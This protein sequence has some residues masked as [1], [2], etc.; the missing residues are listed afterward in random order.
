MLEPL[1]HWEKHDHFQETANA[2]FKHSLK[3]WLFAAYILHVKTRSVLAV[4]ESYCR[5]VQQQ[6][7]RFDHIRCATVY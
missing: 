7:E 2:V 5:V 3:Q 4:D 6:D 1:R